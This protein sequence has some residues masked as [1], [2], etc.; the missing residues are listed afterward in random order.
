[1]H[2]FPH[3]YTVSAIAS[4]G[5]VVTLRGAELEDIQSTPPPE[6][7][8]PAGN[9]SPETLFVA[10]V[11]D[12]LVLTFRAVANASK[13]EWNEIDC[14]ATGVLE[15]TSEGLWFS[16]IELRAKLRIPAGGD[17]ARAQ[18]LLEKAEKTCLVSRSLKSAVH[19][20]AQV[21]CG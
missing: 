4:P 3:R 7:N 21:S 2:P 5:S 16:A 11:A 14:D 6:F 1:M 8:G 18:R 13:L 15:K 17:V 10:A 9:W 20:E 19:L 12:C